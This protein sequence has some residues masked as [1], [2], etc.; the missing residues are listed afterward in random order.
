MTLTPE[1]LGA[2]TG[3]SASIAATVA[4]E[5]DGAMTKYGIDSPLRQAHFVAQCAHESGLFAH[6]EEN[7]NYS[8]L[9]LVKVWP[10]RFYLA[11]ESASGRLDATRYAM[12][13]SALANQVYA[14]RLG[15]GP[16]ESGDGWKYRGRGFIQLTGRANYEA[17]ASD[18]AALSMTYPDVL[19]SAHGAALSAAWFWANHGCNEAADSNIVAAVTRKVN[20]GLTGV[21]E[22]AALTTRALAAFGF[23]S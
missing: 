20:G 15:N 7:L 6:T 17:F 10:K 2:A 12:S 3:C 4:P 1:L 19:A 22:R 23:K 14:N 18:E 16:P 9:T 21:A 11:P 8:A 5:L 13:P